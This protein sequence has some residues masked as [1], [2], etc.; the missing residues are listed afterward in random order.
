MTDMGT[1]DSGLWICTR[2]QTRYGALMERERNRKCQGF[3]PRCNGCGAAAVG[4]RCHR[5]RG[6]VENSV[7][8]ETQGRPRSVQ[9]LFDLQHNKTSLRVHTVDKTV[10]STQSGSAGSSSHTRMS[11]S[12]PCISSLRLMEQ[13]R[14]I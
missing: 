11:W 10:A 4:L 1:N 14:E 7:E 6:T 8:V 3:E 2:Q 9:F 12:N 13:S 5:D